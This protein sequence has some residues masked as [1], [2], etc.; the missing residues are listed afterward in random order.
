MIEGSVTVQGQVLFLFLRSFVIV[1]INR[2]SFTQRGFSGAVYDRTFL[3]EAEK[4][5]SITTEIAK[6]WE[7]WTKSFVIL[8]GCVTPAVR[9]MPV[10]RRALI[11]E[12]RPDP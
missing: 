1:L 5:F 12:T 2:G 4:S 9:W 11:Q 10:R 3:G 7:S 8:T 6:R